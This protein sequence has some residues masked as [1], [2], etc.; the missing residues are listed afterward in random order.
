MKTMSTYSQ[1]WEAKKM[2]TELIDERDVGNGAF[3]A[4]TVI[5]GNLRYLKVEY[6]KQTIISN[7]LCQKRSNW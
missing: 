5:R 7:Y 4:L 2:L 1:S 6:M 3:N